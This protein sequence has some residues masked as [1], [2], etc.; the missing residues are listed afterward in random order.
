MS[1]HQMRRMAC[2]LV[3]MLALVACGGNP[4][5]VNVPRSTKS[6]VVPRMQP[7]GNTPVALSGNGNQEG[8]FLLSGVRERVSTATSFGATVRS[9]S[10]GYY[11][12]GKREAEMRQA[13]SE[14]RLLWA[15]PTRMRIEMVMTTVAIAEGA[16]LVT[17]D[18][19]NYRVRAKGLLGFI[20]LTLAASNAMLATNRNHPVND[21]APIAQM[22]RLTAPGA[23]WSVIGGAEVSGTPIRLVQVDNVKRLDQEITREIIGID[24]QQMALR[25]VINY[26]G[27]TRVSEH[28]LT[29]FV[30]N[31]PTRTEQ[32]TL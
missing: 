21:E 24:P 31:T 32:F 4:T 12:E 22:R 30:W 5:N 16:L 25:R 3:A 14:M 11:K 28:V 20:P 15:R 1:K 18:S 13:S 26:N 19:T 17:L 2:G 7:L 23:V 10:Q 9:Y 6:Q 8:A 29:K 27:N